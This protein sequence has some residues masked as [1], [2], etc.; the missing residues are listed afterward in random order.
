MYD[1]KHSKERAINNLKEHYFLFLIT[2]FLAAYFGSAYS[3]SLSALETRATTVIDEGMAIVENGST[4]PL[5][6]LTN[7]D[8]LSELLEGNVEIA[9]Q[10]SSEKATS[11]EEKRLGA[12]SLG[13]GKGV[14]SGAINN[15]KTGNILVTAY[16]T[17]SNVTK[18]DS[19]TNAI[20]IVLTALVY[21]FI[22][23]IMKNTFI[24]SFKRIFLESYRYEK[25][26]PN[27]FLFL[28]RVKKVFRATWVILVASIYETL[29]DLTIVGGFIKHYSYFMVPYIIAE[30]PT[31]T[32]KQA[33][34]LSRKMMDGHKWEC[35]KIDVSFFGWYILGAL[36]FNITSLLFS[37]IYI[38][39][40]Y[41]EYYVYIRSRAIKGQVEGYELLNDYYLFYKADDELINSTYADVIEIMNDDIHIEDY[42][43]SGVRGFFERNLGVIGSYDEEED[44][45]N[46]AIEQEVKINEFKDILDKKIYPGRLFP[47]PEKEKEPRLEHSHYLRHY[48][49]WSLIALFFIFAFIGWS[50]EV[51]LHIVKDGVFVNRGVLHGPWLPIYGFGGFFILICLYRLR[52]NPAAHMLATIVLCGIVEYSTSW[53]LETTKGTLWWD[54]T[55][56]FL[57]INGRICAEGLLVFALGGTAIVYA[58]APIIDNQIRKANQKILIPICLILLT[59]FSIDFVYSNIH[60]NTG[61]GITDYDRAAYKITYDNKL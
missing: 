15:I 45:Y 7:D 58:L 52:K 55:G 42:M 17:I 33:I 29:W 16:R 27:R 11:Q 44:K 18:S 1:R 8:V 25:V 4:M 3:S 39:C 41:V 30:N 13:A 50:W 54:Y 2:C 57:N 5:G 49:I 6:V 26:K 10:T 32:A 47:I 61:E 20:F 56:Y 23:I 38:E 14:L 22:N 43:H 59:I 37:N 34:D 9:E 60:P 36:T 48:S 40:T 28:F 35:F 51:M 31:V 53:F 21:L 24:V 46:T 19:I 12:I